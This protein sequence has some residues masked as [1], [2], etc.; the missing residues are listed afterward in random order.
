MSDF[1][2]GVVKPEDD[3]VGILVGSNHPSEMGELYLDYNWIPLAYMNLILQSAFIPNTKILSTFFISNAG[4]GKTTYLEFLKR[5]DFISYVL[6]ITPTYIVEFLREVEHGRKKFLVTPDYITF[7]GHNK[8]TIDLA[9]S[10]FRAMIEEGASNIKT[11]NVNIDFDIPVKAGII[12]GITVDKANENTG[13]WK[14]DGFYSRLLPFSYSHS[15]QTQNSILRN[16]FLHKEIID[17]VNMKIVKDPQEPAWTEQID[18][19]IKIVAFSLADSYTGAVYRKYKQ[20]LALCKSS[21]I[22][23]GSTTIERKD[24]LLVQKMANYINRKQNPI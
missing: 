17:K 15:I 13:R 12:S 2:D 14:A 10:Y 9:Q 5:F 1:P 18:S 20:I 11:Y 24:I 8:K 22:L 16:I 19:E 3:I 21:A 7:L 6:D 4:L 23:R